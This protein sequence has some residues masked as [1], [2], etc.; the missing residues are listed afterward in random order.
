[1][2]YRTEIINF[3]GSIINI[4]Y[5]PEGPDGKECFRLF[6]DGYYKN[7]EFIETKHPNIVMGV[8]CGKKGWGLWKKEW[9]V[10]IAE[11]AF[12]KYEILYEFQ[13]RNIE[14]PESLFQDF[15]NT[16]LKERIKYCEKFTDTYKTR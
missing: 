1:M 2:S 4:K 12:T 16:L 15:E 6:E 13:K 9:C 7:K 11:C 8:I 14:R 5:N 3:C 10:G